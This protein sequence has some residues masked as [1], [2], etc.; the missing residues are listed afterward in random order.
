[1][2]MGLFAGLLELLFPSK[3]IFCRRILPGGNA[4]CCPECTKALEAQESASEGMFVRPCWAALSYEGTVRKAIIR[5]KFEG[6]RGYATEFGRILARCVKKQLAGTYDL[7]TWIPVSENRYRKRGYDQAM[8]LALAAALELDDVAVETLKKVVD[9]PAQ[10]GLRD[11]TERVSN[12]LGAYCVPDP[13]LVAGKRILLIDDVVSTGATME[14]AGRT[15]LDAGAKAVAGAA[16]ARPP[17]NTKD[18]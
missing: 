7:I 3:C 8:L 9:N 16:L 13:D 12:V 17:E 14:E 15:L 4:V 1:M 6:S 11:R 2:S 5:Y 10:S 18:C